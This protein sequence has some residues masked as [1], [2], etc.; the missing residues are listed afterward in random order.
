MSWLDNALVMVLII[1]AVNIV[2]VSSSTIRMI[3]TLKGR[4]YLAALVSSVEVI[5]YIIGLSLV[6][7]N[8]GDLQNIIAYAAGYALGIII[9][10]YLE[11]RLAL[12]YITINVVSSNPE[13]E[14]TKRLRKE[15]F[16]VTS[17]TSH[18]MDGDRLSMQILTPR[19]QELR[20]Y[21][22]IMD[23]DPSAFMVAYEP[24]YIKGGF[25]VRQVRKG[26]LFHQSG[27]K[28]G[29]QVAPPDYTLPDLNKEFEEKTGESE[30]ELLQPGES[31]PFSQKPNIK[32]KP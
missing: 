1:F 23:I 15:G 19:K 18:G 26:R 3:L 24:K 28:K 17:W 5:L 20:L 11:D 7:D 27:E 32:P 9:G 6:L 25:W 2:Y 16:G 8:L 21:K 4:P 13:L 30:E 12:G 22:V 14:F 29:Q 31:A 10:S